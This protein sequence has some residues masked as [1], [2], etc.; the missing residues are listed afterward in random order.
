MGWYLTI[1]SEMREAGLNGNG[2]LVYAIIHGYSQ[3][4]D[5]CCYLSLAALAKR[6]GCTPET[7][8]YTLRSLQED[9]FVDRLEFMDGNVHRVAYR[10]TQKIWG[11]QN[12]SAD[13]PKILGHI[14]K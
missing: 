2:L 4:S 11:V 13:P 5:G 7:A 1:T 12:F 8:R 6:A 3:E 9:G 10:A 14:I